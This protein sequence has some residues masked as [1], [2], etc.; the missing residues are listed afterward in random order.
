VCATAQHGVPDHRQLIGCN[1]LDLIIEF[2]DRAD[3]SKPTMNRNDVIG[4]SSIQI[5]IIRVDYAG[6]VVD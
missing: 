1:L 4:E 2:A 6:P 3:V 5:R